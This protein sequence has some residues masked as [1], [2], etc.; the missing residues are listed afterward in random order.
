MIMWERRAFHWNL[1]KSKPPPKG[2]F[3]P[4]LQKL[5]IVPSLKLTFSAMKIQK[6]FLV[7]YHQ[8]WWD[9]SMANVSFREGIKSEG[10]FHGSFSRVFW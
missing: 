2:T 5:R 10:F 9:F 3:L 8:K 6:S 4:P 1:V 7:L